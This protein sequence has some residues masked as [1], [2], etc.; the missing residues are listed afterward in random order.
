MDDERFIG[1]SEL[2]DPSIKLNF[3]FETEWY[4]KLL[5]VEIDE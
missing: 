1:M 3:N 4:G 5:S 2:T